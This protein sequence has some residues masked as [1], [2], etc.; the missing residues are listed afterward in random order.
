MPAAPRKRVSKPLSIIITTAPPSTV[1]IWPG[2]AVPGVVDG[3]PDSSVELGVKFRSDVAGAITGIR[4]YKA[5]ANTGTHV[6][7]LMVEHGHEA[8]DSHFHGETRLRVA[9]GQFCNARRHQPPTR[10]T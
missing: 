9:A 6:G 2:N 7:N 4:F 3:G 1:S 5:T 8:C 10:F